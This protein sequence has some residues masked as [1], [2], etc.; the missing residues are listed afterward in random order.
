MG[1]LHINLRDCDDEAIEKELRGQLAR[2]SRNPLRT[3]RWW[4]G[5]IWGCIFMA[6]FNIGDVHLCVG[7]CD[8]Q[9]VKISALIEEKTDE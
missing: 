6:A 2:Y 9:G 4:S 3:W 5:F 7:E 8:A 1:N